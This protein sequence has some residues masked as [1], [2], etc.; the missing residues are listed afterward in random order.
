MGKGF[1]KTST[2]S[3]EFDQPWRDVTWSKSEKEQLLQSLKKF[4]LQIGNVSQL[5][6]MLHGPIGSGKSSFFNSVNT[7]IQGCNMADALVDSTGGKSYSFTVKLE[8]HKV[9]KDRP[10]SFY[11]FVFADTMGLEP[12]SSNG[13][14]TDDLNNILLGHIKEGY[15]FNPIHPISTEDIDY[16]HDPSLTDRI[17]C[18]LSVL[19]A[20]NISLISEEVIQKM[21]TVRGKARDLGIPQIA[22]M[23]MVDKACPLVQNDLEKVYISK[24]IKEKMKVCSDRLGVPMNCIFPVQNYFEQVTNNV[25]MDI[26]LLMAIKN[27]IAIAN[28]YA[29]NQACAE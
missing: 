12:E 2:P 13:I 23:T 17:H 27:I 6:I 26:L 15:T 3:Q 4:Q 28:D 24:R 9:K 19:P 25:K 11:P 10:R 14:H 1:K 18:L 29:E 20:D 22:I 8:F 21:K 5:R 16:K 7:A